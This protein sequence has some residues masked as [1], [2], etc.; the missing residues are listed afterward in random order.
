LDYL[1]KNILVLIMN[2]LEVHLLSNQKYYFFFMVSAYFGIVAPEQ[3]HA[4]RVKL[5][6]MAKYNELFMNSYI[7]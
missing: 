2:V 6:L 7:L 5:N 4:V 1:R 3:Q